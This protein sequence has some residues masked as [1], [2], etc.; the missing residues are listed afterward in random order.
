VNYADP[1]ADANANK[2]Y[3]ILAYIG[4]LVLVSIFAAPKESRYSRFHA[5]Q[6]LVLLIAEVGLSIVIS[7]ISAVT[8]GIAAASYN[9]ALAGIFG[10]IVGVLWLAYSVFSI[11]LLIL[12]IVN[13]AK[14][15]QKPLPIIGKFT[16]LK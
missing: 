6:G 1:I 11:V 5:N 13:A 7:I 10:I 9:F 2:V 8:V 12:G 4:I 14:G 3:G 16:I 15:V